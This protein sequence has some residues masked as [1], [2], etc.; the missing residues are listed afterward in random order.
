MGRWTLRCR[1]AT[2]PTLAG[3]CALVLVGRVVAARVAAGGPRASSPSA[4][5]RRQAGCADPPVPPRR[6]VEP[7]G[8]RRACTPTLIPFLVTNNIACGQARILFLYLDAANTVASAPDRTATVA[9]YDL[10]RDPDNAVATADGAF[11]W[12][13]EDE[14]GMYVVDVDLPEAGVWGAEFTTEA[15]GSAA[16]TVRLTFEVHDT[17]PTVAVGDPAPASETPTLADVGGRPR[18]DLDRR[19]PRAGLLRDVGGGRARG[20]QAVRARLRHAQVLHER[21]VR[22]DARPAQA[23]R[24]GASRRHVHQRRAVQAPGRRRPA[25]ARARRQRR[26][27][28]DRHHRTSGAS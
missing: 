15:P 20:A 4:A 21:A 3:L 28:G 26:P 14:R 7:A 11:V 1:H 25:P 19:G 17:S 13:I 24:G 5:R 8:A 12:T 10:G 9:F 22:P 18:A 16:E 2:T 23:G 27:P 6:P